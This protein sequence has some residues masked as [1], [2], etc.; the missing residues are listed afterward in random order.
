MSK[1]QRI[2]L[3]AAVL[4]Q[5]AS[6]AFAQL[7]SAPKSTGPSGGEVWGDF[8]AWMASHQGAAIAL[9]VVVVFALAYTVYGFFAK[10]SSK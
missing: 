10:A 3:S 4:L 9:G 1:L 2:A 7:T 8:M 5:L 6:P